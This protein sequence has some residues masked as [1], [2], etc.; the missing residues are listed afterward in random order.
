MIIRK[1][2]ELSDFK[3]ILE[4]IYDDL[5][6]SIY[7]VSKKEKLL[8]TALYDSVKNIEEREEISC[9][10]CKHKKL[11][12]LYEEH[13]TCMKRGYFHDAEECE[14]YEER[15]WHVKY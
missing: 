13:N 4:T 10:S 9:D 5:K 8:I 15:R 12:K 2:I 11:G 14:Y 3:K 1:V 7:S 6:P